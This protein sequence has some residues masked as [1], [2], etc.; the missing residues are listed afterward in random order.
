MNSDESICYESYFTTALAS[1]EIPYINQMEVTFIYIQ[2][3][4]VLNGSW[5]PRVVAV[6]TPFEPGSGGPTYKQ[7]VASLAS[8]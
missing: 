4:F 7:A 5:S 2:W 3:R 6:V 1:S 8:E